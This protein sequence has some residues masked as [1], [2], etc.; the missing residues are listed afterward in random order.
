LGWRDRGF[1]VPPEH[2][3]DVNAGG[4]FVRP[5]VLR[6]GTA[7]ARWRIDRTP[8]RVVLDVRSFNRPT[9]ATRRAVLAEANRLKAF[10]QSSVD[11]SFD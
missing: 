5:T 9:A 7:I 3:R 1:A 8:S 6:D 11:V 10:L 4:G 2:R